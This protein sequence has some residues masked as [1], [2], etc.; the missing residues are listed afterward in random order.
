MNK[1]AEAVQQND[2]EAVK[3]IQKKF[4]K[5]V[6]HSKYQYG[7]MVDSK[8]REG[9]PKSAWSGLKLITGFE[10]GSKGKGVSLEDNVSIFVEK[11]NDFY[12]RFDC[13]DHS[14]GLLQCQ[15]NLRSN[16]SDR[17]KL[18]LQ[19]ENVRK[20]LQAIKLN[21][22]AGPDGLKGMVIKTC[23]Q[24]LAEVFHTIFQWS[25][26]IFEVPRLWKCATIIPVPK[27][28][29][30]KVLNDFRPV[31]LTPIVM[32]CFEK[33]VKVI[34][35][36]QTIEFLDSLQFAYLNNRS[37]EDAITCLLH[38]ICQ[39]LEQSG[40]YVR[41][42]FVDF[43][44]AFNTIVSYFLTEILHSGMDVNPSLC[45]W[46]NNFMTNRTQRVRFG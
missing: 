30:P 6:K 7:A 29:K 41:V 8:F 18:V 25:L 31:V 4:K 21:K 23:S 35:T 36:Q 15:Q 24:Q 17:D 38:T 43:S 2:L 46:I 19:V 42:L 45:C 5:H 28:T 26:N 10:T 39:H 13:K 33:L 16:V 27:I 40:T 20:V 44:S 14:N 9:N 34:L 1:K 37:V 3:A 12:C 22:A 11:L 32:K